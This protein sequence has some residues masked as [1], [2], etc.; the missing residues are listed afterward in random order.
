MSGE[1]PLVKVNP[2]QARRLAQSKGTRAKTDAV[3]ARMLAQM[4]AALELVPQAPMTET[5]R[6]L[7]EL[8]I[9]RQALIKDRTRLANRIKTQKVA[10]AVKQGKVRM[11][12]I[13]RQLRD[14]D[15]EIRVRIGAEKPRARAFEILRS[16]PGLGAVSAAAILIECPEKGSL[17]R[18]QV[19]SLA[20]LA[21][22]T[23][24]SRQWSGR[25]VIQGGRRHLRGALYRPAIVAMRFNPDLKAKYQ[26]LRNAGKPAKVAITALMRKLIEL[27][28]TL[29]KNDHTWM[30]KRA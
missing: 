18:K 26:A 28:N 19:A 30:P 3:D 2:L 17:D 7:K 6:E 9:A 29:V 21:P 25:A 22:M 24:Q 11:A 5:L 13:K 12:L 4:A 16:S 20:G 1:L 8:Q 10:F 23:H 15:I 14:I 27:P